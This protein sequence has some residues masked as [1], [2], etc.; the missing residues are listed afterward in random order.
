MARWKFL[1]GA[2]GMDLLAFLLS[3]KLPGD[4]LG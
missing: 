2:H 4:C 3:R 1:E